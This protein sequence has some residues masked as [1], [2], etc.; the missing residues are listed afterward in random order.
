VLYQDSPARI[1]VPGTHSFRTDLDAVYTVGRDEAVDALKSIFR[2][3]R[4]LACDIETFGLG[5][6]AL[7]PKSVGFSDHRHAVIFDPRDPAQ[8]WAIRMA[9]SHARELI[10]HNSPY[11]VPSLYLNGLMSLD[12][13]AKVSDTLIWSRLANPGERV[14]KALLDCANRYLETNGTDVLLAAFKALGLSKK[15]GFRDFDLDRPIYLQGA[16][17]DPLITYRLADVVRRAALAR[18]LGGHPFV[19][20]GLDRPEAERLVDREQILNRRFLRRS[21]IG[22]LIDFEYLDRYRQENAEEVREAEKALAEHG[23]RAGNGQDLA[24]RLEEMG[25]LP[26]GH[27]QTP[28]GL[29]K[30]DAKA[31]ERIPHSL[32]RQFLRHKK[33][34]KVG[35]DYLEKCVTLAD[36]NGRIH[37]TVNFLAASTGRMSMGDPPIHQFSGPARGIVLAEPGDSMTSIDL[38]QIEPVTMANVAGDRRVL[39]GY[40]VRGE[41]LYDAIASF[42]KISYKAAKVVLLAQMYGEGLAKLT[43]DLELDPGPYVALP[44]DDWRVRRGMHTAGTVVPEYQAAKELRAA[45]FRAMPASRELIWK[46]KN[47]AFEHELIFTVSGRILTIPRVMGRVETHKGVNYFVQGGAYDVLAEA[48]IACELA[49]LGDAIYLAMHDELVVSTSAA[50]DVRKIMETPPARLIKLAGRTPILRTDMA[51]LGERWAAA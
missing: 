42:A 40:E 15:D 48:L 49:G 11:D 18:L 24:K 45:V 12:D 7:R 2:T 27:P 47:I 4:R 43:A 16:A 31:V 8:E 25:A 28:T 19:E 46:L 22:F 32:A 50:H 29:W 35:T 38:A 39:E 51:D 6:D 13:V 26:P 9:M 33:I 21:C 14:R 3:T 20:W 30:M 23:V 36:A 41:K 34:N 5:L 17:S 1:P 10:F 37:P 44:A